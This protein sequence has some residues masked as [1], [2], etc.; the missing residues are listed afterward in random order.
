MN[1]GERFSNFLGTNAAVQQHPQTEDDKLDQEL[2]NVL[3][4]PAP[5]Y[6]EAEYWNSRYTNET[7]SFDWYQPW[8]NLEPILEPILQ[9]KGSAL[10]LGCGNSTMTAELITY[11]FQKVVGFDISSVVIGQMK[12]KY[13]SEANIEWVI[14]DCQKINY[15]PASF[16]V[17]FDKGTLDSLICSENAAHIIRSMLSEVSK[18]LK[19][20]NTRVPFFK[21][22]AL[23]W[24]L[25]ETKEVEKITEPGTY[26]YIYI[27]QKNGTE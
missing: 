22:P 5:P 3:N 21:V 11:G 17:V 16:D 13:A 9:N 6:N 25:Q 19:P 4:H 23:S 27:A 26:H 7:G 1:F 14:G 10:N 12:E 24:T 15:P 8:S 18:V 20:P 2:E